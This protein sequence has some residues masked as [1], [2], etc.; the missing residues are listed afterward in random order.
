MKDKFELTPKKK[1][2]ILLTAIFLSML[3]LNFITPL[4][5]DDF[6]YAFGT[7]GRVHNL[8]DIFNFQ[9]WYYFNWGGRNVAHTLAQFFL[10]NNKIIFNIMNSAVYTL[11]IYLI[12]RIIR[13]KNKDHPIYLLLIHFYL[14][15]FTPAFGQA[16]IWLTGSCNYLWTTTI[17]MIFL[18]LF[19]DFNQSNKKYNIGK[20]I[21]FA[22]LGIIAGW[23]NENSGASIIFILITYIIIKK[24]IDKEKLNKIQY[25]GFIG[26][27]IG[28][29]IMLL[30]PGNFIRSSGYDNEGFFLITWIKRAITITQTA[31][32]YLIIPIIIIVIILSIYF[33]NRQKINKKFYLFGIGSIIAI[34]SMIV[35]PT[36]PERSWTIVIVYMAILSG[37]ILYDLKIKESLKKIIIIDMSIIICFLFINSYILTFKD[38]YRFYNT[39]QERIETIEE[40]KKK[41]IQEYEFDVFYTTQKQSASFALGDLYPDKNDSNNRSYARYFDVKYIKAKEVEE[42]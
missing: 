11:L 8:K 27:I 25:F 34:Y 6:S 21:L 15:F 16:F 35:S 41:G 20:C 33:Y 10:M 39:W 5:M 24:F 7:N 26:I 23:T 30:A 13:G 22:I 2:A 17:I 32:S 9:I 18:N 28:F 14:W 1:I 38:S 42:P 36:F 19:L 37:L 40:G 29:I 31:E 12:Y 4:I 3:I